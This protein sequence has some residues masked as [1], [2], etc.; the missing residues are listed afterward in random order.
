MGSASP[1]KVGDRAPGLDLPDTRGEAH[2]LPAPGEVNAA[3][4]EWLRRPD[5]K[6][7]PLRDVTQFVF[8]LVNESVQAES[9]QGQASSASLCVWES[10]TKGSYRVLA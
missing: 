2:S 3:L 9:Q 8:A 1:T 7:V 10:G 6:H 4:V 5:W